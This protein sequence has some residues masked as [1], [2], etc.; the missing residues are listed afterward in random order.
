M[1][2]FWREREGVSAGADPRMEPKLLTVDP[3]VGDG[4]VR[5]RDSEV[6]QDSTRHH[7]DAVYL[8]DTTVALHRP[9][10]KESQVDTSII[11]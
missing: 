3:D 5:G 9:S 6:V 1:S 2:S 10:C 11:L 7:R 8:R 4:L